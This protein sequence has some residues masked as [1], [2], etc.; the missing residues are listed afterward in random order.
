[1]IIHPLTE[2]RNLAASMPH[3][4]DSSGLVLPLTIHQSG[5][6]TNLS[7][8]SAHNSPPSSIHGAEHHH[9]HH[10]HQHHSQQQQQQHTT[11][12]S[13]LHHHHSVSPLTYTQQIPSPLTST[14]T[15]I[16]NN[17]SILNHNSS[18]FFPKFLTVQHHHPGTDGPM[19]HATSQI[20][21]PP[22]YSP[23]QSPHAMYMYGNVM[24]PGLMNEHD[25]KIEAGM[26]GHHS[27][28]HHLH[29]HHQPPPPALLPQLPHHLNHHQQLHLIQ[30][31]QHISRSPSND[32]EHEQAEQNLH[33][34]QSHIIANKLE[35][36][37]VV[38]IKME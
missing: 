10:Q 21:S 18:K 15:P 12:L 27:Q 23:V 30:Q 25:V 32:G 26:H 8:I 22:S 28:L 24:S 4:N 20:V 2:L 16:N 31:H 19:Y 11:N 6:A 17:I 14:S 1:M 36:P 3:A 9:H 37:S 34:L 29:S 33:E 7:V 13:P 38:N 5:G 35:R